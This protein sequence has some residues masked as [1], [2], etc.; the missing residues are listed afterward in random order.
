MAML[1]FGAF[2][3]R[4]AVVKIAAARFT[5]HNVATGIVAPDLDRGLLR[6]YPLH[7]R[8]TLGEH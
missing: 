4:M 6:Q 5:G 8:L 7:Q 3:R 2:P 1:A